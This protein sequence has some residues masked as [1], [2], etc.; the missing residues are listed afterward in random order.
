MP[1]ELK[2]KDKS[3]EGI[4]FIMNDPDYPYVGMRIEFQEKCYTV[5]YNSCDRGS[6]LKEEIHIIISSYNFRARRE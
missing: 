4:G 1:F 6:E 2:L 5:S 3:V